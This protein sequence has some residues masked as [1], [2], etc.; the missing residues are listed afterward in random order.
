MNTY[1]DVPPIDLRSRLV[2]RWGFGG[3]LLLILAANI[4]VL[5][6]AD[7]IV[8]MEEA[9]APTAIVLGGGMKDNGEQTLMQMD[10]VATGIAL[11]K[12]GQVQKLIM[13]GDDGQRRFNEVDA[14]KAQAVAAGVPEADIVIDPHAYRTYLSCYHAAHEYGETD[15]VLVTQNFHLPRALYFCHNMGVRAVGVSSDVGPYTLR[16]RVRMH[17]RDVLA[18][19]KAVWQ[20]EVSRPSH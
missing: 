19:V 1:S 16:H 12:N 15:V 3:L 8:P 2:F 20:V 17:A 11:Y 10:R 18:R 9:N 4:V 14:M 7:A 6:Y 5:Q 13:S